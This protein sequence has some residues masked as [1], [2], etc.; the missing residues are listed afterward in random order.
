LD[1]PAPTA[2]RRMI[3]KLYI[4]F[5]ENEKVNSFSYAKAFY[6]ML[7][8]VGESVETVAKMMLLKA[9]EPKGE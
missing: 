5:E 3:L 4:E 2:E 9:Q 6:E 1:A 7:E 8:S